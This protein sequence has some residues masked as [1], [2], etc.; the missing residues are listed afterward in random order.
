MLLLPVV[1]WNRCFPAYIVA[2]DRENPRTGPDGPG[3]RSRH[4][5]GRDPKD[6]HGPGAVSLCGR[7]LHRPANRICSGNVTSTSPPRRPVLVIGVGSP[8]PSAGSPPARNRRTPRFRTNSSP[9]RTN[10]HGPGEP[11]LF[12]AANLRP[13]PEPLLRDA[14][15]P[16][17]VP[18]N[19]CPSRKPR[20][21]AGDD[22]RRPSARTG[23]PLANSRRARG[24]R[25]RD[26]APSP[27]SATPALRLPRFPLRR[28]RPPP[29]PPPPPPAAEPCRVFLTAAHAQRCCSSAAGESPQARYN[30]QGR[31]R[32]GGTFHGGALRSRR[33]GVVGP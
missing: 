24:R 15:P 20:L 28:T 14:P 6:D 31:A 29:P 16:D 19:S 12:L 21:V 23:W 3:R 25:T 26:V 8:N 18:A 17:A 11:L 5:P 33:R 22:A 4:Q 1:L 7:A 13:P 27:P 32:P 2:V 30:P 10:R 9:P